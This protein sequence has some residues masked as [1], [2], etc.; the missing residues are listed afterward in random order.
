MLTKFLPIVFGAMQIAVHGAP[1][2]DYQTKLLISLNKM[3]ITSVNDTGDAKCEKLSLCY[4]FK[5]KISSSN[6]END[7]VQ[8]PI[9]SQKYSSTAVQL[10]SYYNY[11]DIVNPTFYP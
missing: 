7:H 4:L 3:D 5:K 10:K 6:F 1:L 11:G 2:Y 9:S 8:H